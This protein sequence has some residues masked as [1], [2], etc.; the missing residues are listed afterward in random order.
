[1]ANFLAPQASHSLI[2]W[3]K[4]KTA[5]AGTE[6]GRDKIKFLRKVCR[7]PQ[8]LATP[9]SVP[10]SSKSPSNCTEYTLWLYLHEFAPNGEYAAIPSPDAIA[11]EIGVNP[12]TLQRAAQRLEDLHL[13][14]FHLK[15]WRTS[16]PKAVVKLNYSSH[17]PP[18][19][20]A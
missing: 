13:C 20:P 2:I 9:R 16:D 4:D 15:N 7:N 17:A 6:S 11:Q 14:E 19:E 8:R 3:H 5:P 1:M 12:R 10:P 18:T